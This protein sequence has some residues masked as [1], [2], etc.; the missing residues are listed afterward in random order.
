MVDWIKEKLF[1]LSNFF[2][3]RNTFKKS[4]SAEA[5]RGKGLNDI[6]NDSAR[7]VTID[8]TIDILQ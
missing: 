5:I 3:R 1:V 8:R 6:F 4:S 2:F 7:A